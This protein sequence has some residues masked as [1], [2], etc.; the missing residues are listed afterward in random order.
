MHAGHNH[1][2]HKT[3]LGGSALARGEAQLGGLL[4]QARRLLALLAHDR[5]QVQ[6]LHVRLIVADARHE[7]R[8]SGEQLI[9]QAEKLL[10]P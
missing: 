6:L 7:A 8:H 4:V 9:L 3:V 10:T 5:R 1:E 2:V